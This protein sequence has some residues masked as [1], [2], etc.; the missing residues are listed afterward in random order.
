MSSEKPAIIVGDIGG[1][2]CRL[3]AFAV[4]NNMKLSKGH[5]APGDLFFSKNYQ[6]EHFSSFFD[7]LKSFIQEAG[8]GKKPLQAAC[9]AVAGPIAHNRAVLTNRGWEVCGKRL[10]R[11]FGIL[12]VKVINDF[13]AVG[14]GLLT[15][16]H[17][18]ECEIL[19]SCTPDPSG[20]I[21]CIGAGTGLGEVYLTS[22]AGGDYEAHASEGGHAEWCPKNPTHDEINTKLKAK[23]N[24][25]NRISVERIVSGL[26]I[27][28]VYECLA[29]K[30]PERVDPKVQ[31]DYDSA[32]DL[33]AKVVAENSMA[34]GSL[35]YETMQIFAEEYGYEAAVAALKWLP[36]GGLY[37]AGGL[38]PKNI[39]LIRGENSP[40]MQA[41]WD[42]GRLK[43]CL[44]SIPMY[45]VMEGDM[46]LRGAHY[47]AFQVWSKLPTQCAQVPFPVS[48]EDWDEKKPVTFS[49]GTVVMLAAVAFVAGVTTHRLFK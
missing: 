9:F 17:E 48:K 44:K 35:C 33:R 14:Y 42:K 40:F 8:M 38:T 31:A 34:K 3:M 15:L 16:D 4:D 46:G 36:T 26:G 29:E 32:G 28:A 2:N 18:R 45:A 6:N 20:P 47:V 1:T 41:Y 23:Y 27:A 5:R 11:Q 43:G 37:V 7:I 10:E 49:V 19:N 22:S 13:V 12:Q 25:P 24:E 30:Y 21:A 39:N